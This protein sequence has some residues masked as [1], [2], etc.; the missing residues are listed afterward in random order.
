MKVIYKWIWYSL[1]IVATWLLIKSIIQEDFILGIT[2]LSLALLLKTHY[3]KI[4]LPKVI[5]NNKF[6]RTT[7]DK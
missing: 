6:V 5:K 4:P 3:H 7:I 2:A 1:V